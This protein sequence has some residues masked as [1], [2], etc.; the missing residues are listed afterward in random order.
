MEPLV[1]WLSSVKK[2]QIT[3]HGVIFETPADQQKMFVQ[4]NLSV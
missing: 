1:D 4:E 2:K 3:S